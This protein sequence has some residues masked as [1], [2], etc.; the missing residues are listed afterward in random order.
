MHVVQD[1]VSKKKVRTFTRTEQQTITV[2]YC[3]QAEFTS[4][5]AARTQP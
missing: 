5:L 4:K 3:A 2:E 1:L